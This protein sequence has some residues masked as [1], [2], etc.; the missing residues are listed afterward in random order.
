MTAAVVGLT[1]RGFLQGAGVAGLGLL[2]GCGR[3][4]EH[5]VPRVPRVGV[6]SPF[7]ADSTEATEFRQGLRELGYVEGQNVAVAWRSATGQDVASADSL[8]AELGGLGVDVVVAVT[9]VYA[10]AS[11]QATSGLPIVFTRVSDPVE[12]GLVASVGRPGAMRPAS[13]T[14]A[15]P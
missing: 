10:L 11:M 14:S 4:P 7:S 13:P 3:W 6:L 15:A 9:T 2:A 1:R 5:A 12:S 8:A